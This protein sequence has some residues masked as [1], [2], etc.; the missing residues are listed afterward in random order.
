M[1]K[2]LENY[3]KKL[4]EAKRDFLKAATLAKKN[5][6]KQRDRLSADIKKIN[7]RV[8]RTQADLKVKRDR[9]ASVSRSTKTKTTQN[10]KAA[11][12]KSRQSIADAKAEG[13]RM[14]AELKIVRRDLADASRHLSHALHIDRAVTSVDVKLKNAKERVKQK[15]KAN[16]AKKAA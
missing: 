12:A 9:L 11:I 7:T 4:G 6:T 10:L 13:R 3:R 15:R 1:H 14:R 5:L 16:A 2:E 8:V